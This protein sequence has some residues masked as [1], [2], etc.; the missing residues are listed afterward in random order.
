MMG[1]GLTIVEALD[2]LVEQNN[3]PLKSI[4]ERVADRVKAGQTFSTS[5]KSEKRIF[6]QIFIGAVEVGEK[7]GTLAKDLERLSI[8][9]ERDFAIRNN[10]KSAMVYPT[11]VLTIMLAIGFGVAKFILPQFADTVGSFGNELPWSTRAVMV[12][13]DFS[14]KYGSIFALLFLSLTALTIFLSRKPFA[15]PILH[16]LFLKIPVLNSFI[17]DLNRAILFRSLGT[18]LESGIPIQEAFGI[19]ERTTSNYVYCQAIKDIGRKISSGQML[20]NI[21]SF[22]PILFPKMVKNMVGVGERSG[23]MSKILFFLAKYYEERIDAQSKNFAAIFEPLLLVIAGLG[24]LFLALA[25]ILP[26]Y[27]ITSLVSS[28]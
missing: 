3:D 10:L 9:M 14:D 15:R 1:A 20:N 24:V 11:L 26:I 16:P 25:V 23:E 19:L 22:H 7:T 12:L 17:H 27:N 2:I 4:L 6:N 13:A 8:Q 5:L 21:L 18:L 28:N